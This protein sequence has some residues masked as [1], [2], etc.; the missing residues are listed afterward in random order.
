MFRGNQHLNPNSRNRDVHEQQQKFGSLCWF[1]GLQASMNKLSSFMNHFM[2]YSL[3]PLEMGPDPLLHCA[4]VAGQG[5]WTG[6]GALSTS[7]VHFQCI[8]AAAKAA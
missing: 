1:A 6:G 3:C 8:T 4:V 7:P 5:K 2:V